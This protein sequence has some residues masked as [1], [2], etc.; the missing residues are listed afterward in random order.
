M[1]KRILLLKMIVLLVLTQLMAGAPAQ[2][3][4]KALPRQQITTL[5]SDFS[6]QNG[7]EVVRVGRLGM[8]LVKSVMRRAARESGDESVLGLL[9]GIKSVSV[10]HFE[11]AAPGVKARFV[12]RLDRM[13]EDVDLLV[14]AKSDGEEMRIFG[15]VDEDGSKVT[16]FVAYSPKDCVLLCLYGSMSTR[17]LSKIME[18]E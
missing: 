6:G 5:V 7:F 15:V 16:D 3:K 2:A 4:T 8:G 11:D 9:R 10:V 14:E 17:Q 18:E 12:R 1:K 13:L